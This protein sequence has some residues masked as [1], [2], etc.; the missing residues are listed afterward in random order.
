MYILQRFL[1]IKLSRYN[2]SMIN[3]N[4]IVIIISVRYENL[5]FFL[6]EFWG[7]RLKRYR[8]IKMVRFTS[9]EFRFQNDSKS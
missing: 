4:A 3:N 1:A 6:I 9:K 8:R 5:T 2:L 7:L